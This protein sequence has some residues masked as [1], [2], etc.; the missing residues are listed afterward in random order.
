MTEELQKKLDFIK[1]TLHDAESYEHACRILNFD[2]ETICPAEGM[3][4]QGEIQAFLSN[5]AFKLRKQQQFI[6]ASEYLYQHKKEL[7]NPLDRILTED[8]HREY[9]K[10]KNI[11]PE[12]DHEF[13]LI[14]NRAFVNWVNAKQKSDYALFAP[15]LKEVR[16]I[17][18]E[19]ISLRENR[20]PDTYDNLLDDYERGIT[21]ADLDK[22]FGKCRERLVP[23]LKKIMESKKKI[24]TDFMTRPVT[25]EQQKQMARYLLETI[26]FDFRRGSFT[27]TE[28]PFTDGLGCNDVRVTT[29]YY[30]D[31]FSSSMFSIIH[32]CG[33]ALFEMYQPEEDWKH[34]INEDKTMGMHESVSRFYENRIGRSKAFINLIYDKTRQIFP[35]VMHDVSSQELYEALNVVRPSL[36]RTEADEFTYTFHI[37][38][39]YELEKL[40][41][42]GNI[43]IEDL[44]EL[45]N[46]A[47]EK[48]LG[49]R[50]KNDREGILQDVHWA[51]GFGYF[52][53]YALGNMYNAMYFDTM[54]RDFDVGQAV[55]SGDFA[56]INGW[57]QEHVWKKA[58]R[59]TPKQWIQEITGRDF[60]ADLYLDYLEKKYTALY[61]IG[62]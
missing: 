16:D 9:L 42:N 3:E 59:E 32:E 18:L 51:S 41:V 44:P 10:T 26:G 50:P 55:S 34:Y 27:T 39:R 8:I 53:T 52:T 11:T 30:P 37:I 31:M 46:G 49:I 6:E 17:E 40:I 36:V 5:K 13:A 4:E 56:K 20:L 35:E 48:Y 23:L 14:Y 24:R 54:C 60:T 25:D 2:Q 21:S 61:G 15:S 58:N 1:K 45:W 7:E 28:H 38:I 12:R 29:H 22:I 57:M 43:K 47:Y 33:H 62:K 19:K